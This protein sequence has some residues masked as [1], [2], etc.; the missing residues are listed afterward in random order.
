MRFCMQ[1]HA[2]LVT[3]MNATLGS[4][5]FSTIMDFQPLPAYLADISEQKGG[6]MLGLEHDSRNKILL[7][8]GVSMLSPNSLEQ[9]PGVYQQVMAAMQR[10]EGF[11]KSVGSDAKFVYLNYAHANQD[12]LGSYG[13]A[14]VEHMK[15]AAQ[16]YDP[17]GFFQSRV[18][19]GFKISR[20]E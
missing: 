17:N 18:P 12:A 16:K 8:L 2:N 4:K 1:Q 6:N 10:I 15:Q 7:T 9:Y 5:G 11:A 14:N 3:S 13:A 19:G 20:V